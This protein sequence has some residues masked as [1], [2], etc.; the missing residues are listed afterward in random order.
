MVTLSFIKLNN[1][2]LSTPEHLS[3]QLRTERLTYREKRHYYWLK[4]KD[5]TYMLAHISKN[6]LT[7]VH[8]LIYKN[9][10]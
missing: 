4:R 3:L 10:G 6:L 2:A 8:I 7:V 5:I 9:R 1:F